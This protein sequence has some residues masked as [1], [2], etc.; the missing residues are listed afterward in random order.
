MN[1]TYRSNLKRIQEILLTDKNE[2]DD[3]IIDGQDSDLDSEYDIA[4]TESDDT[5]ANE[6]ISGQS[7]SS[8]SDIDQGDTVTDSQPE[9]LQKAGATWSIH[10]NSVQG[11]IS[12]ANIMKKNRLFY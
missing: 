7:D 5:S 1:T 9:P 3:D 8:N 11:R 12:A 10:P 2:M 6:H 4:A